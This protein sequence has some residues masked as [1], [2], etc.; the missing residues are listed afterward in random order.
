MDRLLEQALEY[1]RCGSPQSPLPAPANR[2]LSLYIDGDGQGRNIP[3]R[4]LQ[5]L[6]TSNNFNKHDE[7]WVVTFSPNGQWLACGGSGKLVALY[8]LETGK[9]TFIGHLGPY[10]TGV[11][12]LAWSPDSERLV[13]GC[14]PEMYLYRLPR[15][16]NFS[17][18]RLSP[19]HDYTVSAIVWLPSGKGFIT[20][21]QDS[22]LIFWDSEGTNLALWSLD[23]FRI[24]GVDISKDETRLVVS[25]FSHTGPPGSR[26]N[27]VDDMWRQYMEPKLPNGEPLLAK[28]SSS[29]P[30]SEE[31]HVPETI[32]FAT[33]SDCMGYGFESFPF[34]SD[35]VLPIPPSTSA[36]PSS[37]SREAP[38]GY[39][40]TTPPQ[41]PGT[42]P[43]YD[44]QRHKLFIIDLTNRRPGARLY[45]DGEVGNVRFSSD[46]RYVLSSH[47]DNS[48]RLWYIGS[49]GTN[50]PMQLVATYHGH[51]SGRHQVQ[52]CFGGS[53]EQ[54]IIMGSEGTLVLFFALC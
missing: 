37:T 47:M 26:I 43:R 9:Y 28:H 51:T 8:L 40:S 3:D 42:S 17:G 35:P 4:C 46:S 23:P 7:M 25:G 14:D 31:S 41:A 32:D 11:S 5:V 6:G 2:I 16:L 54:Y 10:E 15:T 50:Q 48:A 27:L 22:K 24:L 20:G 21:G 38:P 39:L 18:K 44:H 36:P 52:G 30:A 53:E 34:G 33:E 29:S 12:A 49:H 13:V 19:P 1:Q 45:L